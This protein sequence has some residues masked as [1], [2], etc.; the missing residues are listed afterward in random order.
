MSERGSGRR[1]RER[2]LRSMLRHERQT[3]AMEWAAALHHSRHVVPAQHIGL[4]AQKTA[5][6]AGARLGLLEE[7][8]REA[9]VRFVASAEPLDTAA[10]QVTHLSRTQI[11]MVSHV[12]IWAIYEPSVSGSPCSVSWRRLRC[13]ENWAHWEMASGTIP[14]SAVFPWDCG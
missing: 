13:S 10:V 3:V 7:P 8:V 5:N 11:L 9:T 4:R 12:E 2:R 1:R 6:S 14:Y